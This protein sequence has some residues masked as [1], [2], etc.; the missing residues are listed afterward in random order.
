MLSIYQKFYLKFGIIQY[1]SILSKKK[2]V[3]C[4]VITGNANGI[5]GNSTKQI[6]INNPFVFFLFVDD[7]LN[8]RE[9][10]TLRIWWKPSSGLLDQKKYDDIAEQILGNK[11][12]LK[13]EKDET[14]LKKFYQDFHSFK[15]ICSQTDIV[16]VWFL[17]VCWI[18]F[19]FN[20]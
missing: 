4:F 1:K 2:T 11:C 8:W 16:S 12:S 18:K 19:K 9:A 10:R 14:V 7:L 3:S 13:K 15:M 17:F 5:I 20:Y 6:Q